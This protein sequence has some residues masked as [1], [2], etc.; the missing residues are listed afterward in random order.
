MSFIWNYGHTG[1]VN[2]DKIR[3]FE[4]SHDE[5]GVGV[6]AWISDSESIHVGRFN[7]EKEAIVFLEN[8]TSKKEKIK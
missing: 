8:I 4:L 3:N 2:L 1:L 5:Y 7:S 6:I